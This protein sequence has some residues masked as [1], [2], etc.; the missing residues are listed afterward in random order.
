MFATSSEHGS[1]TFGDYMKA[2]G[3]S[4]RMGSLD[5][6]M[7]IKT[8]AAGAPRAVPNSFQSPPSYPDFGL[9]MPKMKDMD[10][11]GFPKF[12]GNK[13][14][15][16]ADTDFLAWGKNVQRIVAAQVMSDGTEVDRGIQHGRACHGQNAAFNSTKL[17]V[18]KAMKL[19]C[20]PKAS[21]KTWKEHIQWLVHVA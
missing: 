10:W 4:M 5:E 20:E 8:A 15:A 13:I 16:G 14:Y 21:R 6:L 2:R 19:M 3:K 7:E 1:G 11:P 17:P 18:S 9:K 12:S